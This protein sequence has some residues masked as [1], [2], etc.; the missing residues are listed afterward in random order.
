MVETID[1]EVAV[2]K[3]QTELLTDVTMEDEG[4]LIAIGRGILHD[5][6][7]DRKIRIIDGILQEAH[8]FYFEGELFEQGEWHRFELNSLTDDEQ[9]VVTGGDGHPPE[10][11][12]IDEWLESYVTSMFAD[13]LTEVWEDSRRH[14][15]N[16]N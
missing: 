6:R 10:R 11:T 13:Y 1:S 2:E 12:P 16:N 15:E 5:R 14:Y 8:D 3:M 4:D 7:I 9:T